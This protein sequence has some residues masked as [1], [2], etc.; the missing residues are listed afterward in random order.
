M[1][2]TNEK[3]RKNECFI[4]LPCMLTK[5]HE[6]YRKYIHSFIQLRSPLSIFQEKGFITQITFEALAFPSS[7]IF[8]AVY[9]P[10]P[11]EQLKVSTSVYFREWA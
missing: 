2:P 8:A 10:M 11:A 6:R 3:N 5:L 1:L 4:I 7:S 9:L